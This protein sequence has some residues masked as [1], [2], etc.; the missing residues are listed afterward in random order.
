[1]I[2]KK[3]SKIG[4][5]RRQILRQKCT[6]IDFGWGS[7]PDPAG[8]ACNAPPDHL[9]VFKGS[10]SKGNEGKGEERRETEGER[11]R[12]GSEKGG[13]GRGREGKGGEGK[14][15]LTHPLSQ[16]PVYATAAL[17]NSSISHS[18]L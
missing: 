8:G 2:L 11:E 15:D 14:N 10:T 12:K 5:T 18:I 17:K 7:A 16:I 1:L 13:Q 3:S 9:A 6:K 4:A